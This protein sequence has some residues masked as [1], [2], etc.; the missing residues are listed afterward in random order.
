M[1]PRF[2]RQ[3]LV[4]RYGVQTAWM[5]IGVEGGDTLYCLPYFLWPWTYYYFYYYYCL[6]SPL[7]GLGRYFSFLTLY[8]VCRTPWT[9]DQPVTRPLPTHRT[10]QT[11]NKRTQYRHPGLECDSNPLSQRSGK[12]RQFMP[13][14][15]RPLR[16]APQPT[17]ALYVCRRPFLRRRYF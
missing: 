6:Y 15:A 5:W 2:C 12:R 7:L 3:N 1:P 16:S 14:T 11:Q 17:L 4:C 8:T 10:T 13:C 9:G